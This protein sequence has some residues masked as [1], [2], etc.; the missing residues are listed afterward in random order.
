M[1]RKKLVLSLTLFLTL[2]IL[3]SCIIPLT[4]AGTPPSMQ[5]RDNSKNLCWPIFT[6]DFEHEYDSSE[7]LFFRIGCVQLPSEEE[8]GSFPKH[9]YD[10]RL[11]I[12]GEKITLRRF[13][14]KQEFEGE[15]RQVFMWYQIFEPGYF[16]PDKDYLVRI[17]FWVKKPY[18][19]DGRN[20]WRIFVDYWGVNGDP[21]FEW[22]WEYNLN[23]V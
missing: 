9:P 1:R 11:Y 23:N 7:E 20:D 19:D 3:V 12:N 14:V 6:G 16:S 17:E 8:D 18:Q 15:D 21:G 5:D 22:V 4:L 2:G 13:N 10:W